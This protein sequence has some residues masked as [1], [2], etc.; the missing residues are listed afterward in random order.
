MIDEAIHSWKAVRD[1]A[2]A[3]RSIL[4]GALSEMHPVVDAL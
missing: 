1:E 4:D 2:I 3:G